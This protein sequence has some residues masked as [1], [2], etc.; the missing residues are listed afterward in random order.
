MQGIED[1]GKH[2]IIL[3]MKDRSAGSKVPEV[4][5]ITDPNIKR[6]KEIL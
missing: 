3:N 4:L 5:R 6:A 2:E 1:A